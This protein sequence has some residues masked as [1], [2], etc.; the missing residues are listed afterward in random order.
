MNWENDVSF[1]HDMGTLS[2]R[3]VSSLIGQNVLATNAAFRNFLESRYKRMAAHFR[4]TPH[5]DKEWKQKI[6]SC[7]CS[8]KHDDIKPDARLVVPVWNVLS[9]DDRVSTLFTEPNL[10]LDLPTWFY[11]KNRKQAKRVML[12]SQD[13]LRIGDDAGNLYISSPWAFHSKEF[14]TKERK[15]IPQLLVNHLLDEGYCV[16]LTDAS[17]LFARNHAFCGRIIIPTFQQVF[18][19]VLMQEVELFKPD[20]IVAVGKVAAQI[21]TGKTIEDWKCATIPHPS[22]DNV[23]VEGTEYKCLLAYHYRRLSSQKRFL[24]KHY[25]FIGNIGNRNYVQYYMDAIEDAIR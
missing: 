19:D 22:T 17:K 23:S 14:R 25:D 8:T 10:G 5:V 9:R 3:T 2:A 13:P 21:L 18:H 6:S 16:Y 20:V 4:D 11:A 15:E 1:C 12:V 7:V 24:G